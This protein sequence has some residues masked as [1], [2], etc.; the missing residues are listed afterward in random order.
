MSVYANEVKAYLERY[1]REV[2]GERFARSARGRRMGIQEWAPQT[3]HSYRH[4]CDCGGHLQ[5]FQEEYRTDS[6]G[7]RYRAKHAVRSKQGGRL[8]PFGL[9]SMMR[10]RRGP[11]RTVVLSE[12]P[13]NRGRL[14]SIE[15]GHR[16]LTTRTL[17]KCRFRLPWISRSTS[18][19]FNYLTR[20]KGSNRPDRGFQCVRSAQGH[21]Q[22]L[23]TGRRRGPVQS[24]DRRER[25]A[26]CR[27]A[28][29][30]ATSPLTPGGAKRR[31]PGEVEITGM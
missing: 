18:K 7:Q 6:S 2:D 22:R 25:G 5:V 15:N 16:R 8:L 1:Q 4:R 28:R 14:F 29:A 13:A 11:F 10:G 21:L 17:S 19:N 26:T 31:L 30:A 20:G 23:S 27:G 12:A 3:E 9:I 24:P